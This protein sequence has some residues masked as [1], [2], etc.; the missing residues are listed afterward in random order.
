MM[1]SGQFA[2][3]PVYLLYDEERVADEQ[4]FLDPATQLPWWSNYLAIA[5]V[6]RQYAGDNWQ[7]YRGDAVPI[8]TIL[9]VPYLSQWGTGADERRG[10]CGPASVGMI[11]HF[12]TG[13]RPT[14][15]QVADA[16]GQPKPP[17]PGEGYTGHGQLRTGAEAFGIKLETRSPYTERY[18]KPKLTIDL[19]LAQVDKGLPSIALVHYGV[20]REE[21]NGTGAIENQDQSFRRGHWFV[22]VGYDEQQIIVNDPDY[23]GARA[24]QGDHR[25]IPRAAFEKSLA[26]KAPGCTVGHQGL[27]VVA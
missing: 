22:V 5:H 4:F 2:E 6:M 25:P 20:L 11:V 23:W 16:C 18:D 27:I 17:D 13:Y 26:T 15:D 1:G 21:T 3:P 14:V 12:R 7:V 10:D 24:S 9:G 8:D 19:L